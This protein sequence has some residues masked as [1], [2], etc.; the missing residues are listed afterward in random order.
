MKYTHDTYDRRI[1][2]GASRRRLEDAQIL[3][4]GQRWAGA[5]YV[6]GYAIEC[7]LKALLCHLKRVNN[8]KDISSFQTNEKGMLSHNL[9]QL[10]RELP[11]VQRSIEMDRTGGYK[12]AWKYICDVWNTNHLRYWDKQGEQ[13][14]GEKFLA[15]VKKL[16][17]HI[18][19]QQGEIS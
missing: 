1:L 10:L 3:A 2:L 18:L 7:S 19:D 6:G 8:L 15:A 17:R 5:M 14:A 16:H 12:D 9:Q 4:A 11:E 13:Q